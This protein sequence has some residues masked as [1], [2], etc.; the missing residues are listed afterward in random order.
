MHSAE[1]GEQAGPGVVAAFQYLFTVA[2]GYLCN[3][4]CKVDT[5]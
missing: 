2:V 5:A 3:C 1:G 4:S